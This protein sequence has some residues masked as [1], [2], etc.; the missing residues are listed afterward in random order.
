[1]TSQTPIRV[2]A[3]PTIEWLRQR[4]ADRQPA[5]RSM[6]RPNAFR[7]TRA[8]M[9]ASV[10]H[11]MLSR[12]VR[13]EENVWVATPDGDMP[14]DIV[15]HLGGRTVAIAC[16]PHGLVAQEGQDALSLVYG[17]FDAFVRCGFDGTHDEAV[18]AAYALMTRFP[19]LFSAFGRLSLSRRATDGM[20]KAL[21]DREVGK[22]WHI[23]SDRVRL[24]ALRLQVASDW[25]QAFESALRGGRSLPLSA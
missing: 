6:D 3:F 9:L 13:I 17:G 23:A 1:M 19:G 25:V 20:I 10:L 15:L 14:V 16:G 4:A 8:A 22:G 2:S 21:A 7:P 11:P 18:D 24:H 5:S 12:S